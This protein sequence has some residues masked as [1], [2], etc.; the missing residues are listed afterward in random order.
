MLY[1][2]EIFDDKRLGDNTPFEEVA[3]S[4]GWS[5]TLDE[6]EVEQAYDGSWYVAG[7]APEKPESLIIKEKVEEAR[8][9]LTSTD[10]CVVKIAEAETVEEQAELRE[11]YAD[12]I[13]KRKEARELINEYENSKE[14]EDA[15]E[16]GEVPES[17]ITEHQGAEESREASEAGS[18]DSSEQSKEEEVDNG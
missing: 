16:E 9:F 2:K 5:I 10:W 4:F 8:T 18:S 11:K 3:K 15:V 13:K 6:S 12:T 14:I 7:Y 1:V 17:D